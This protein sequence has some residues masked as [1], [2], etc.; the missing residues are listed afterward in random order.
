[1]S[2]NTVSQGLLGPPK[3]GQIKNAEVERQWQRS[4]LRNWAAADIDRQAQER[5]K[6]L[7]NIRACAMEI[8]KEE[9]IYA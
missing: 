3:D 5:F 2:K 4:F 7:N 9:I 1:M 6:R 8:V